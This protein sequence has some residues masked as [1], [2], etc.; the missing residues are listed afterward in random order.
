MKKEDIERAADVY[1]AEKH[2]SYTNGQYDNIA[3]AEA[4]EDG[5]QWR[6]NSVWHDV[7]EEPKNGEYII[8]MTSHDIATAWH[9]TPNY[10]Q[11]F[12]RFNIKKWAYVKDL[13]PERNEETK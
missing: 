4:F 9:A 2:P 13:L 8:L 11:D 6:I 5:A 10:M 12:K 3:I 1:S 7:S